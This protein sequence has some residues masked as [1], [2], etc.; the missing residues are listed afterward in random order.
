MRTGKRLSQINTMISG[1]YSDIWDCCC[2][3]GLLGITL[4][5]RQAADTIHFVDIVPSLMTQLHTKLQQNV[6]DNS[7][8]SHWQTHCLDVSKL[9]LEQSHQNSKQL[10]IIAGV[11]GDLLIELLNAII[12]KYPEYNLEFLLCPVHHNYKVRQALIKHDLGLINEAIVY[13]N[14]RFYEII[15]VATTS[16]KPVNVVG[17]MM[18][19]FSLREHQQYRHETISHYQRMA[20]NPNID[21]TEILTVYQQLATNN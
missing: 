8:N 12:S 1:Q 16:Q 2:D 4:L 9:P 19:D 20:K 21:V 14:K 10:I 11:G 17:N 7:N 6:A 13:E 15:H 18:W 3:H 5:K